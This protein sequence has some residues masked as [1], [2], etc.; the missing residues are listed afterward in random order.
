MRSL[1]IFVSLLYK[2]DGFLS[3]AR[4]K[5]TDTCFLRGKKEEQL[6]VLYNINKAVKRKQS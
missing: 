2:K 5:V 1:T 6:I 4:Q 3:G